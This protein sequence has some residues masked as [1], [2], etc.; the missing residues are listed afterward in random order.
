[1]SDLVGPVG[2]V[3]GGGGVL[4]AVEVGMIRALLRSGIAPDLVVGPHGGE[5]SS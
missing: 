4:G 2:F 1:M 3:L 5:Y